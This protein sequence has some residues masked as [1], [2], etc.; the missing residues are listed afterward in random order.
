LPPYNRVPEKETIKLCNSINL[1]YINTIY[2]KVAYV[3]FICKKHDYKGVQRINREALCRWAQKGTCN[4]AHINRDAEDLRREPN[5]DKDVIVLGEYIKSNIPILCKC[6]RCQ[7]EFMAT[8]N[9]LQQGRG[10][11]NCRFEK[12]GEHNRLGLET[13]KQRLQKNFPDLELV[14]EYS[15]MEHSITFR[16][17]RCGKVQKCSSAWRVLSGDRGCSKCNSSKGE[18]KIANYL[19]AHNI[20]YEAQKQFLQCHAKKPLRFD[21]YIPSLNTC[22]EYQGEQHYRPVDFAGRHDGSHI[23]NHSSLLERDDIKRSFCSQN[24]I[25]LVEIPYWEIGNIEEKLKDLL[26]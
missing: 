15:G 11:P 19:D 26:C 8:P 6:K 1:E 21:F 12:I 23:V 13:Y 25:N 3:E 17:K 20:F 7:S 16:C 24:A 9:K 10:C 5:L 18:R 14:G 22:I 2:E 4:C